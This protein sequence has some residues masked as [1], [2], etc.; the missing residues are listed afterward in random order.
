VRVRSSLAVLRRS[1][2]ARVRRAVQAERPI[3]L[4]YHRVLHADTPLDPYNIAVSTQNLSAQLEV[5]THARRVVPLAWLVSQ[6]R[7]DRLPRNVAAITFDDGYADVLFNAKPILEQHQCP[8][9][10][11]LPMAHITS[12]AA[13]WWDRLA[14]LFATPVPNGTATSAERADSLDSANA[15]VTE[16]QITDRAALMQTWARLKDLDEAQ[17]SE[18]LSQLEASAGKGSFDMGDDRCMTPDEVRALHEPGFIDIGAHT[19]THPTLTN[20]TYEQQRDEIQQSIVQASQVIG[21]TAAGFAYPFGSYDELSARAAYTA[22]AA[23]AVTTDPAV[24]R[25]DTDYLHLPRVEAPN[26]SAEAFERS[27]LGFT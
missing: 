10:M 14:R 17:R 1:V 8:A 26:I 12:G 19:M 13:F 22:G 2:A 3:I 11:F 23:Y 9:T 20:L 5:L 27:V 7:A 6:L 15:R 16:L 24:I 4:M 21:H 18:A 25:H